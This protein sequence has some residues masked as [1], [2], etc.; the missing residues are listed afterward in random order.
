M[1]STT[2]RNHLRP[3]TASAAE[4]RF[5]IINASSISTPCFK[6]MTNG[7]VT[8]RRISTTRNCAMEKRNTLTLACDFFAWAV[9]LWVSLIYFNCCEYEP[10]NSPTEQNFSCCF[11][12]RRCYGVNHDG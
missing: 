10:K 9:L 4:I 3:P 8:K 7:N 6:S 2:V 1:A 12:A 11:A 5:T